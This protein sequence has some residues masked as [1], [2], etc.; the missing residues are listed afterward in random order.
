MVTSFRL[1][2]WRACRGNGRDDVM[3]YDN[4][5]NNTPQND[6]VTLVVLKVKESF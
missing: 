3:R 5:S 2:V 6:D 1:A 4:W